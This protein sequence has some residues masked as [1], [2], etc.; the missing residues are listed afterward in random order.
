M[1]IK[2]N[3]LK[4]MDLIL[5]GLLYSTL[6]KGKGLIKKT[7]YILIPISLVLALGLILYFRNAFSADGLVYSFTE[8]IT[9]CYII[10]YVFI[11]VYYVQ[12][13]FLPY[14]HTILKDFLDNTSAS[15]LELQKLYKKENISTKITQ[16]LVLIVWI[17][18]IFFIND[19][20]EIGITTWQQQ[21]TSVENFY[22][23]VI[24]YLSWMLSFKLFVSILIETATLYK[25]LDNCNGKLTFDHPDKKCGLR[26][27]FSTLTAS[28]GFGL[29]YI[30]GVCVIL[31]SDFRAKNI[32]G[33]ELGAY[34]VAWFIIT[35]AII[36][37]VIYYS[38]LFLTYQ[39]LNK[40]LK[41]YAYN[42][43]EKN[44]RLDTCTKEHLSKCC[45]SHISLN[46]ITTF[47]LA[48]IFPGVASIIAII[49]IF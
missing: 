5:N 40:T 3:L 12:S 25:G 34:K 30:F 26:K 11:F 6:W 13:L 36:L 2:N 17:F 23:S 4:F 18:G 8:D 41:T 46:E 37:A 14:F 35:I 9:N 47:L 20:K 15:E 45:V 38:A 21:L 1:K 24:V 44:E 16:I 39:K 48:V 49:D 28:M 29:Y 42:E 33:I 10:S 7:I 43:L 27:I 32:Y 31:Y 22:Y 19:A